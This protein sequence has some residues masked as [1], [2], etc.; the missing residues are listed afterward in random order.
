MRHPGKC[1]TLLFIVT[2][3]F[4]CYGDDSKYR[5][6]E[7]LKVIGINPITLEK[8]NWRENSESLEKTIE[9]YQ[10][11]IS[12]PIPKE[13]RKIAAILYSPDS[14][15]EGLAP[16]LF[17]FL[18]ESNR[19]RNTI[20]EPKN[21]FNESISFYNGS[22]EKL[23]ISRKIDNGYFAVISASGGD[24]YDSWDAVIA[25]YLDA[26][27]G[28]PKLLAGKYE[29][30]QDDAK[31]MGKKVQFSLDENAKLILS[32]I[33]VCTQRRVST[34]EINLCDLLKNDNLRKFDPVFQGN[35]STK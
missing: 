10:E 32:S 26:E 35:L 2:I 16:I 31:C 7:S 5:A 11:K 15:Y 9:T 3:S 33:D 4:L 17:L 13:K 24:W 20:F 34:E 8:T 27:G 19:N 29:H 25:L 28:N 21:L 22:I 23:E 12:V 14:P 6:A 1:K 30:S 18:D